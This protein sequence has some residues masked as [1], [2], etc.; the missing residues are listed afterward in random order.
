MPRQLISKYFSNS[1]FANNPAIDAQ[2]RLGYRKGPKI[3]DKKTLKYV[4]THVPI[5][6]ISMQIVRTN[7]RSSYNSKQLSA[8]LQTGSFDQAMGK[9]TT[10]LWIGCCMS[11]VDVMVYCILYSINCITGISQNLK[12]DKYIHLIFKSCLSFKKKTR[13][14]QA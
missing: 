10:Q 5:S 13:K 7:A 2:S 3:N 12:L 8:L 14:T 4:Y 6:I 1:Q 11:R 9:D